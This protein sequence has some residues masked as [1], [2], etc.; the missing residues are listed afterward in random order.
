MELLIA[1]CEDCI[2]YH[3]CEEVPNN[4]DKCYNF[5]HNCLNT[6]SLLVK[7]FAKYLKQHSC[8]YNLDNYHSFD[9]VDIDNLDDLVD[10]FLKQIGVSND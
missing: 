10:S 3:V 2:H 5:K 1:D 8:F 6:Y 9:A 7:A 4:P